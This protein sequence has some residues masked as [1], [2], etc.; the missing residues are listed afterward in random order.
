MNPMMACPR[1]DR[2]SAPICPLDPAWRKRTHL[3][4]DR[5]CRWLTEL[6]KPG[7][8]TLLREYLA[9]ETASQI[10]RIAPII[11]FL[12]P[13]NVKAAISRASTTGSRLKSDRENARRNFGYDTEPLGA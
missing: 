4:E 12:G 9:E 3:S 13:A 10:V 1:Y 7:G 6:A 2:C 5:V 8:E 11:G